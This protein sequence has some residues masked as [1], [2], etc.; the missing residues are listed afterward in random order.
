MAQV[1]LYSSSL[2]S[3]SLV[4][5]LETEKRPL[6]IRNRREDQA[7]KQRAAL[8]MVTPLAFLP[9]VIIEYEQNKVGC[10]CG[11]RK[12]SMILS[13]LPSLCF[14]LT[15]NLNHSVN[16]IPTES[17]LY[18]QGTALSVHALLILSGAALNLCLAHTGAL[19]VRVNEA[20]PGPSPLW[21]DGLLSIVIL[22]QP[23]FSLLSFGNIMGN[24]SL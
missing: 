18:A 10:V 24:F 11:Q 3:K 15:I 7:K 21:D 13:S 20:A 4:L 16:F 1:L 8:H 14:C 2:C 6:L 12:V 17:F 23:V 22:L 19:C 5:S 9:C